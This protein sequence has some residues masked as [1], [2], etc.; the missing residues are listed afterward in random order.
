MG[1]R[2]HRSTK[3]ELSFGN[4]TVELLPTNAWLVGMFFALCEMLV[5]LAFAG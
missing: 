2:L 5:D 3:D 4:G 1:I